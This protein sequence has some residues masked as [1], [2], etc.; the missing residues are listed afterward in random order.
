MAGPRLARVVPDLA[1][2]SVSALV[3]LSYSISYAAL[4]FSGP[5][6]EPFV[7]AGLHVALIAA[8]VVAL[9]IA[10]PE[11]GPVRHWRP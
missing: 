2:G 5:T 1:A 9:V 3:T 6:L 8:A 4:I 10:A 11:L 7:A